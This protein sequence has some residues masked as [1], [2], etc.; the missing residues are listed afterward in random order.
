MCRFVNAECGV[1]L[2]L[3]CFITYSE[4]IMSSPRKKIKTD[5]GSLAATSDNDEQQ[6]KKRKLAKTANDEG[7]SISTASTTCL[8]DLND[9]CLI[10]IVE[11]FEVMNLCAIAQSCTR[12]KRLILQT[13]K[14]KHKIVK[15]NFSDIVSVNTAVQAIRFFEIFG[16]LIIELE[17]KF[18]PYEKC[19]DP[20]SANIV[21]AVVEHCTALK[22]LKLASFDIPDDEFWFIRIGQLF[23]RLQKLHLKHVFIDPSVWHDDEPIITPNGNAISC[24][25]NCTSLIELKLVDSS[26]FYK[27]IFENS[28]QSLEHLI[29]EDEDKES[30]RDC[31]MDGFIL[32]HPSL[33]T[34]SLDCEE[35]HIPVAAANLARL[36]T[37]GFQF[38]FRYPYGNPSQTSVESLAKFQNLKELSCFCVSIENMTKL[39]QVLPKLANSL[40]VLNLSYG[41]GNLDFIRIVSSMKKLKIVRLT[42]IIIE[43]TTKDE[44]KALLRGLRATV[45]IE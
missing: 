16:W 41:R 42:D 6:Q 19:D 15:L 44:L 1:R 22:A 11:R 29:I 35:L 26:F 3:L 17:V 30:C 31:S 33:K 7:S 9:D 32:R 37:F 23:G 20:N 13:F 2:S 40:E 28:F 14:R 8:L 4:S 36:E 5:F 38:K 10:A 43:D 24:F 34:F 12:L 27:A 21:D 18:K 45:I 39:L 25:Y